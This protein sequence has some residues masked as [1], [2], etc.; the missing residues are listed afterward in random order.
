VRRYIPE[1]FNIPFSSSALE[2]L[3]KHEWQAQNW[4][5]WVFVMTV[6]LTAQGG[7]GI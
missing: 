5:S 4:R 7:E 3:A 6:I 1:L 2:E